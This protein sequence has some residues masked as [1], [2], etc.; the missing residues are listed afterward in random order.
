ML[1]QYLLHLLSEPGHRLLRHR[2]EHLEPSPPPLV[3]G[4]VGQQEARL[5]APE[6]PPRE[7]QHGVGP[8]PPE[9][10]LRVPQPPP[11]RERAHAAPPRRDAAL[12][13]PQLL[14]V[15]VGPH[16]LLVHP[17]L[18][19]PDQGC[20]LRQ[21]PPDEVAGRERHVHRHAH[22]APVPL[23][24]RRV[25]ERADVHGVHHLHGLVGGGLVGL[26]LGAPDEGGENLEG[27]ELDAGVR[28]E[29]RPER[30]HA[31]VADVEALPREPLVSLSVARRAVRAEPR[32]VVVGREDGVERRHHPRRV[33]GAQKLLAVPHRR[34]RGL[35]LQPPREP[36]G[37]DEE[38]GGPRAVAERVRHPHPQR[39][40][41][42][43]EPR[44]L[45]R[46]RCRPA[47]AVARREAVEQRR[48]RPVRVDVGH[49]QV[50]RREDEGHSVDLA[51]P[52]E[53]DAAVVAEEGAGELREEAERVGEGGLEDV[54]RVEGDRVGGEEADGAEG[55]VE[56]VAVG[57]EAGERQRRRRRL[58]R[59]E[60]PD[61][62]QDPQVQLRRR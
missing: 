6:Q 20:R 4:A 21:R 18:A 27:R 59:R 37:G 16:V 26:H 24:Q 39:D 14:E 30:L 34:R 3:P 38:L 12:P 57:V 46:K 50:R 45:E 40:A 60:E 32:G 53:H 23:W 15:D 54:E 5:R 42:A 11:V 28:G 43:R 31:R 47:V 10:H 36:R 17:P 9:V 51:G 55:D 1:P 19:L 41:A 61:A 56:R 25:E 48:V 13:A 2:D 58:R 22:V 8:A 29:P 62:V 49:R 33:P 52:G 35:R 7:R 44:D